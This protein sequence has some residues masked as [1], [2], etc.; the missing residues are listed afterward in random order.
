[1]SEPRRSYFE[2]VH[3]RND[4]FRYEKRRRNGQ[5]IFVKTARTPELSQN[6][7]REILWANFMRVVAQQH[8]EAG[9]KGV[10]VI[11]FDEVGGLEMEYIDAPVL[12]QPNDSAAWVRILDRYAD[13][14]VALDIT[15]QGDLNIGNEPDGAHLNGTQDISRTWR[16]WLRERYDEVE[17]LDEAYE[18]VSRGLPHLDLCMQHGDL[19]P[20]QIFDQN[21][22]WIVYDG[23][24]SGT[25]LPRYN[26]LAYGFGRLY[27][28]LQSPEAA[29]L[30]L[31]KF[32]TRSSMSEG[33]LMNDFLPVLTFRAVGMI[34]DAYAD[35]ERDYLY[36]ANELLAACIRGEYADFLTN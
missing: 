23:E 19:T 8:P 2:N 7:H 35:A 28:R 3:G 26:D 36:Y 20:W 17:M 24:K 1:M 34:G 10:D 22:E 25:H 5:D 33:E 21:D 14:L 29:R 6:L 16:R 30:L 13:M 18:L 11:G 27:T 12:V 9:L 15:A 32:V 4:R 31:Q